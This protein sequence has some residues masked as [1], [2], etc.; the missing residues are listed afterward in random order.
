MPFL[1]CI[2]KPAADYSFANHALHPSILSPL[3][4]AKATLTGLKTGCVR[5]R[6]SRTTPK[7]DNSKIRFPPCVIALSLCCIKIWIIVNLEDLPLTFA[8]SKVLFD[9]TST[10]LVQE[11]TVRVLPM[12]NSETNLTNTL[13]SYRLSAIDYWWLLKSCFCS[14]PLVCVRVCLC[15]IV[16]FYRSSMI[17]S[18]SR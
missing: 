17:Q 9:Q 13:F 11:T 2:S 18:C 14:M 6:V 16:P 1:F 3:L 12:L 5:T 4:L 7:K 8:C 15:A 10:D